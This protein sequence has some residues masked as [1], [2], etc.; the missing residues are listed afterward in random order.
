MVPPVENLFL[1]SVPGAI[2]TNTCIRREQQKLQ[3]DSANLEV[4][5]NADVEKCELHPK[6]TKEGFFVT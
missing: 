2:V 5:T 1:V 3:P 4:Q 6:G